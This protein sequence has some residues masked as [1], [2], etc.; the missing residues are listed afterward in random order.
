MLQ[1]LHQST[2]ESPREAQRSPQR[3]INY[4]RVSVT[5]L[6]NYR[7]VYCMPP[8]GVQWMPRSEILTFEEI[9]SV[10]RAAI[11]LGINRVRLTGGEPLIRRQLPELV[12]MLVSLP[13]IEETYLTT[14][15]SLLEEL[16]ADLR[17]NGLSRLNVS[18]DSLKP[19][20]YREITRGGSI[21]KV[22][23][24]IEAALKAGFNPIK[25]NV[26]VIKDAN[27]DE[28]EE[29]VTL[30]KDNPFEVRFI[31]YMPFGSPDISQKLAYVSAEEMKRR[32]SAMGPLRTLPG[33]SLS[34]P[35]ER[36]RLDGA[37]GAIGFITAMSHSFCS[38]CNRI[39]LT[40]DGRLLPC[41]FSAHSV[42]VKSLL[43]GGA[44]PE[45]ITQA[46]RLAIESKPASRSD[47][48]HN[49]MHSI[50]G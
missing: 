19:E 44:P 1:D 26:V 45:R 28:I 50:G 49:Y 3:I 20:R 31:E 30:T 8:E 47:S 42:E 7:C 6:C 29:F 4:L 39:R 48:C 25:L 12:R 46:L 23:K 9:C 2:A 21:E 41:L 22:W 33:Q 17:H 16:A 14:N 35:A 11:P 15:G 18:L 10:V 5:D 24:G 32:I 36:Y 34:G 13:G 40:A 27:D 37:K 43:R 38:R